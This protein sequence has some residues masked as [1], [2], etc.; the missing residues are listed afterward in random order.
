MEDTVLKKSRPICTLLF[1][2]LLSACGQNS[3]KTLTPPEPSTETMPSLSVSVAPAAPTD[4]PLTDAMTPPVPT[5]PPLIS[6]MTSPAPTYTPS[7]DP[8]AQGIDAEHREIYRQLITEYGD[9]DIFSLVY[10]DDDDIPEL[11]IN[12]QEPYYGRY[13]VIYTI[14]T[15]TGDHPFCMVDHC[16]FGNLESLSFYE[17]C[18]ILGSFDRWNNGLSHS[19]HYYQV[20]HDQ[21]ITE[22]TRPILYYVYT[23][24]TDKNDQV[25][26]E[27][28]ECYYMDQEIDMETYEKLCN[29]LGF[30][31][32]TDYG[33]DAAYVNEIPC[34][35]KEELLAILD[36]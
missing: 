29:H 20:S 11:L 28:T 27:A 21:T 17:R 14:Y 24:Q 18:G 4:P 33:V 35:E 8:I 22:D 15:I 9:E 26:D 30:S 23:V 16:Y 2:L 7:H 6:T 3:D 31:N 12:E 1:V 32:F 19:R 34:Y 25:I 10:L 36:Q 13:Y 5:D